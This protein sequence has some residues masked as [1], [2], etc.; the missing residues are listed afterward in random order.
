MTRAGSGVLVDPCR[1]EGQ[2]V[3]PTLADGIGD[4]WQRPKGG[5]AKGERAVIA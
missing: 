4:I 2:Q 1:L 5:E 3:M